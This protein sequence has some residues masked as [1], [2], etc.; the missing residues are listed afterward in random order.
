MMMQKTRCKTFG[1]N[2]YRY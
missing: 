1:N 2:S